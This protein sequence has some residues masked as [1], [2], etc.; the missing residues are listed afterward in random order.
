VC[1][2]LDF[3]SAPIPTFTRAGIQDQIGAVTPDGQ[4]ILYLKALSSCGGFHLIVA[5]E[6]TPG[7]GVFTLRDVTTTFN[8]LGFF[9][10]AESYTI[11][12]DGRTIIARSID[13]RRL[14]ATKRSAINM[15]DFGPVSTADFD[16]L[17]D[18]VAA[19]AGKFR[20]PVISADGLELFYS[21]MGAPGSTNGIYSSV[22]AST[23]V[24]FPAGARIPAALQYPFVSGISSDR[25]TLFVFD[26]FSSRILTRNSTS[27]QFTN[28]NAPSTPTQIT[29]WAHRPL[30]DCSKLVATASPGGCSNEDIV[31][32]TRR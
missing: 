30:A 17:N 16:R 13:S 27:Q 21:V 31:L 19:N 10:D 23:S 20:A 28:P 9:V 4:V 6:T 25:L 12:T 24:P 5:D 32:M 15:V 26:P 1:K 14:L 8:I 7:S 22:R 2:T 11:T 29:N 18:Q 3:T